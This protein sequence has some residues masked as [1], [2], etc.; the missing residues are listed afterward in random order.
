MRVRERREE[1]ERGRESPE[2]EK[3]EKGEERGGRRRRGR[4]AGNWGRKWVAGVGVSRRRRSGS[5]AA[6]ASDGE[7]E[8]RKVYMR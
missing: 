8:G 6:V 4:V 3:R 2:K 5:P 7:D 1:R